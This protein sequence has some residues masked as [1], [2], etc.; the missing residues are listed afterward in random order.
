[1]K[2]SLYTIYLLTLLLINTVASYWYLCLKN[3]KQNENPFDNLSNKFPIL[4][5]V[6]LQ[7]VR[8]AYYVK[9]FEFVL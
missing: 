2:L 3:T 1:M 8:Q 4:I 5:A 7:S 6:F 9:E